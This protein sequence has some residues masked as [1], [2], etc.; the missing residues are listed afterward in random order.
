[1]GKTLVILGAGVAGLPIAHH[2]IKHTVPQVKDLK[3]ILV[4]PNTDH[5]WSLASVRAVVPGQ[6]DDSKV[7]EPIEP[8]FAQYPKGSFEFV[9]GKAQTLDADSNKVTVVTNDGVSR[10]IDYDALV[11]ATGTRYKNDMPW[12]G[13]GTTEETKAKLAALRSQLSSAKSILVAGG[14]TSGIELVSEIAFEF[15]KKKDIT[16]VIDKPLPL[17]DQWRQDVR[18]NVTA[19]IEKLGAKVISSTRV[20]SAQ[21]DPSAAGRQQLV[22]TDNNG[23]TSNLTVDAYLPTIGMIPN[24]EFVPAKLLDNNGLVFQDETLRV[25]GY[26]NLF[27][28]GDIGNLDISTGFKAELQLQHLS[29]SLQKWFVNGSDTVLDKYVVDPKLVGAVTLGRSR[30][31]GQFGTWKLFSFMVYYMKGKFMGTDYHKD[32]V[33]GKRTIQVKNW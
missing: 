29:K 23:K 31:T 28:A 1:M 24:N 11:I 10:T 25:P 32:F 17:D 9:A 13:M 5:Y 27:V 6:F 22:L 18:K 15:G 30:G 4:T 12:K 7:F 33:A 19:E 14:G 26:K 3:V 16:F 21:P 2:V 8:Q 20:T